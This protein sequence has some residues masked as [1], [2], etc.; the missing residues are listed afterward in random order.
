M[1]KYIDYINSTRLCL[2]II[3]RSITRIGLQRS[4]RTD[5]R[6]KSCFLGSYDIGLIIILHARA[7]VSHLSFIPSRRPGPDS[8]SDGRCS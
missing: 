8:R 7:S 2:N 5:K 1:I 6:K 3:T 4:A